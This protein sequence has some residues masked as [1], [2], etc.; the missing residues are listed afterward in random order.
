MIKKAASIALLFVLVSAS[1]VS[2]QNKSIIHLQML[3]PFTNQPCSL[4]DN[5]KVFVAALGRFFTTSKKGD[6]KI[7]RKRYP[8]ALHEKIAVSLTTSSGVVLAGCTTIG[9]ICIKGKRT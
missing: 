7:N 6:F 1:Q 4:V 5:T 2:A 9:K 8:E 3:C